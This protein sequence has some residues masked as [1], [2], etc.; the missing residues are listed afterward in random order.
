M[1]EGSIMTFEQSASI[2]FSI[3]FSVSALII[4]D[5]KISIKNIVAPTMATKM[6]DD[7]I[8]FCLWESTTIRY[9]NDAMI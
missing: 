2:Q 5:T 9:L 3:S 1:D 4:G 8:R 7:F 6:M